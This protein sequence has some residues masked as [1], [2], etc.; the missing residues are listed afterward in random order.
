M[1]I[2]LVKP[3]SGMHVILPPIGLGYLA[4]YAQKENPNI[5]FRILDC[6]RLRLTENAFKQYIQ[7]F[8]PDIIGFTALSMEI[9]S[10]LALSL[11]AKQELKDTITIL[12][13]PHAS[14]VPDQLLSNTCIDYIFQGEAEI[15][16][17]FFIK[18]FY[19]D[20]KLKSPGL[21]YRLGDDIV[22]N[23]PALVEDL[24]SIPFPDY[25]KM[26]FEKYPK[27]Y[28]MKYFPAA[29]I[30]SSRGCPFNCTFCAGHKVSG[31]KWRWR[32]IN[33]ITEEIMYLEKEYGI[34]EIDFWDDNFTLSKNR[35]EEFCR[36]LKKSGK[37][38]KWWCPNGIHLN[39]IDKDLLVQMKESGCYAV[40]FGV[41]SGSDR[42]RLDMKKNISNIKLK[43][44]VE[45]A[46]KI[47]LR[48]QGFFIIGYP[49]EDEQDILKTIQL[50]KHLP[51]LRASF[52]IFQPLVGS[53]IYQDLI[54]SKTLDEK[55][56]KQVICDYSKPSIPTKF[57]KD[58]SKI[59]RLQRKAILEFY[60]RPK[61]FWKL[62]I[63]NMS[64]SQIKELISIIREYVVKK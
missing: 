51:F 26:Q 21:G 11:I 54:N 22:L 25:K 9:N 52:C 7:E 58:T 38:L 57:I 4:S 59:K 47:G 24:D 16:F 18:N 14:A 34:K 3:I 32:S 2:L 43:E 42:I 35:T 60:L 45:F 31:K 61:I 39:T 15:G 63:E 29:P 13:G 17:S 36:F 46:Y 41:E 56:S 6:N 12:G 55:L 20:E 40:A 30:M 50:S 37:N 48:T 19:S 49:T 1:K 28:F 62:L 10:C 27:M 33:N 23:E 8:K 64:L 44:M 53:N 5:D